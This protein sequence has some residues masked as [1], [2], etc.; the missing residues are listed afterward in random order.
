MSKRLEDRVMLKNQNPNYLLDSNYLDR[1]KQFNFNIYDRQSPAERKSTDSGQ[2]RYYNSYYQRPMPQR[3][4]DEYKPFANHQL[5]KVPSFLN[6]DKGEKPKRFPSND[7]QQQVNSFQYLPKQQYS[8]M[9]DREQSQ[10]RKFYL[11]DIVQV[12][13]RQQSPTAFSKKQSLIDVDR[14]WMFANQQ[15]HSFFSPKNNEQPKLS[16]NA[17]DYISNYR[18]FTSLDVQ[19]DKNMVKNPSQKLQPYLN[20]NSKFDIEKLRMEL[21]QYKRNNKSRVGDGI[22]ILKNREQNKDHSSTYI[23]RDVS[24]KLNFN[25]IK[26]KAEEQNKDILFNYRQ[27]KQNSPP[28]QVQSLKASRSELGNPKKQP[29]QLIYSKND[30]QGILSENQRFLQDRRKTPE[31]NRVEELRKQLYSTYKP[32]NRELF[33]ESLNKSTPYNKSNVLY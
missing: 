10:K 31:T 1:K 15:Q 4:P 18:P 8:S 2:G 33:F 14:T 25:Y 23:R 27:Q 22:S 3:S 7:I 19:N 24:P 6:Y 21:E 17:S 32:S 5:S 29:F 30:Q 11:N 13:K 9:H 20:N 28:K 16:K 26:P 12:Q